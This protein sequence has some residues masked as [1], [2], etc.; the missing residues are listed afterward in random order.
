[1]NLDSSITCKSNKEIKYRKE[2]HGVIKEL[3]SNRQLYLM[4][5]PAII[6]FAIFSYYPYTF[7]QIAF[8]DYNFRDG[9]WHSPWNGIAN[10]MQYFKS[11]YFLSTTVNTLLL[12]SLFLIAQVIVSVI[13]AILLNE[14]KSKIT[15]KLIQ[16]ALFLPFFLSWIIISGFLYNMLGESFGS[17][18]TFLKSV[19]VTPV[20]WYSIPWLWRPILT[21]LSTW[22][23]AGY[24]IVIYLATI[25]SI[26]AE[27]YEAAKIDG[28]NRFH[29]MVSITIPNLIPTVVIM[30]LLQIGKIFYGNFQMI[31]SVVGTNGL[32]LSTTDI[33]DTYVFRAM[34]IDGAFGMATAVG[35]YQSVLGIIIVILCNKLANK[36]DNSM[37]LF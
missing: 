13:F 19:G 1:M 20:A 26:D 10:F 8:K 27:L 7:L 18:N 15:K 34:N 21:I 2:K 4:A 17:V 31:Y 32:L 22:Q 9:V 30:M 36:Y 3:L 29:E 5:L 28:A 12:N 16:S 11:Q 25:V 23:S 35:I 6:W 37:G 24:Y 33:I 14:M